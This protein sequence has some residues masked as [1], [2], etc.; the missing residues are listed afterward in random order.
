[1]A[2]QQVLGEPELHKT[3]SL[4]EGGL[5]AGDDPYMHKEFNLELRFRGKG[6]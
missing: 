4:K 1:M 3:L 2:A 5:G 6:R